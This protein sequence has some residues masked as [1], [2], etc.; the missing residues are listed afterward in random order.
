[1]PF[2]GQ[3]ADLAFDSQINRLSFLKNH[4]DIKNL[5]MDDYFLAKSS[6]MVDL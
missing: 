6:V 3:Y 4:K 1:M 5:K 2:V